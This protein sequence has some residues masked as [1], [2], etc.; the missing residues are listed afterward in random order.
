M[1][2]DTKEIIINKKEKRDND[3][4]K[5]HLK[6]IKSDITYMKKGIK[7]ILEYLASLE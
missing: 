5:F 2:K 6:Q 7:M 4:I 1:T 3:R